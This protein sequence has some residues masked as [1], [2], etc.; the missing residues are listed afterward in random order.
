MDRAD[1]TRHNATSLARRLW[2][3]HDSEDEGREETIRVGLASNGIGSAV[4]MPM[5]VYLCITSTE[6]WFDWR[7]IDISRL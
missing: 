6:H 1:M 2:G 5:I 3:S 7:E 4:G